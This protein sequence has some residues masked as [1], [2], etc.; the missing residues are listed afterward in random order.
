MTFNQLSALGI[1]RLKNLLEEFSFIKKSY[2][3]HDLDGKQISIQGVYDRF[4]IM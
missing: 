2:E 3:F 4:V 1:P